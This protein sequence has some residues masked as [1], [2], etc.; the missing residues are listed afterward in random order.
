MI[1]K[2]VGLLLIVTAIIIGSYY[3]MGM[4]TERSIKKNFNL[5][6]NT[7]EFNAILV[8]YKRGWFSSSAKLK[9]TIHTPDRFTKNA[10]GQFKLIP[11]RDKTIEMPVKIFHGPIILANGRFLLGLGYASSKISLSENYLDQLNQ[12]FT[13]STS[14]PILDL[15]IFVSFLNNASFQVSSPAFTL[16]SK[17]NNSHIE[18]LGMRASL[19]LSPAMSEFNGNIL[20]DGFTLRDGPSITTLRKLSSQYD[21]QKTNSQLFLGSAKV[22]VE[23]FSVQQAGETLFQLDE[24]TGMSTSTAEDNLLRSS[25]ELSFEKLLFNKRAYGPAQLKLLIKDFDAQV[26][27]EINQQLVK[28]NQLSGT[29]K[30]QAF[31]SLL[32]MLPRLVH[33]GSTFEI[34][35]FSIMLPEG[36]FDGKLSITMPDD[37]LSN[38]FQFIQKL[39]GK[40]QIAIPTE[41]MKQYLYNS[42]KQA[43]AYNPAL[44]QQPVSPPLNLDAIK[45][46]KTSPDARDKQIKN[47]VDEKI[48]ALVRD[49][50]LLKKEESYILTIE[51]KNGQLMVNEKPFNPS[52][53]LS[54]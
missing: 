4:V 20:I 16:T 23:R 47:K 12:F 37:N 43:L 50:I 34:K 25:F 53:L 46:L 11:S 15:S 51:L 35:S 13:S 41:F 32:T 44:L 29:E 24:L 17:K 30:G 48:G 40:G 52:A 42:S 26:L 33:K 28:M 6:N 39:V 18:W 21:L 22:D 38:P 3:P 54:I 8:D 36:N 2:I 49:K 27:G 31:F 45:E 10:Q 1:K 14:K 7:K 19:G 5:L 9:A